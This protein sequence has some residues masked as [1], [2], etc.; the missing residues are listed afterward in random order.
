M[1]HQGA[2]DFRSDINALAI[3]LG[4]LSDLSPKQAIA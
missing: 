2:F 4:S 1:S 3:A